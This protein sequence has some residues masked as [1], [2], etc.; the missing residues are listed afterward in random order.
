MIGRFFGWVLLFGAAAIL[1]RDGLV[2]HDTGSLRIETFNTLWYE[3]SATS[4]GLFRGDVMNTMPWLWTYLLRPALSLWAA[5]VMFIL[6]MI[7]LW[8]GRAA[9][10]RRH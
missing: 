10:R 9:G 3:L 7:L 6:S 1:V 4:L 2:W 5:P 8:T